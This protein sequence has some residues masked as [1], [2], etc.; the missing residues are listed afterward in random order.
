MDLTDTFETP[1]ETFEMPFDISE[2]VQP[3]L[4][5]R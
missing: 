3:T 4:C 2:S 5:Q 1:F